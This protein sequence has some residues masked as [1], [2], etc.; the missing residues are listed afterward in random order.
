MLRKSAPWPWI[1][2]QPFNSDSH[3]ENTPDTGSA[4]YINPVGIFKQVR[5]DKKLKNV[6]FGCRL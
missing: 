6:D 1:I 5:T 4:E 2:Q 3:T